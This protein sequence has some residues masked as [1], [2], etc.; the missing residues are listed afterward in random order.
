[1]L[2]T[3]CQLQLKI[4]KMRIQ[5]LVKY[6]NYL[7]RENAIT[8]AGSEIMDWAN[9]AAQEIQKLTDIIAD[10]A[11]VLEEI[12]R[13]LAELLGAVGSETAEHIE[14]FKWFEDHTLEETVSVS[15]Q[16]GLVTIAGNGSITINHGASMEADLILYLNLN[17]GCDSRK[18]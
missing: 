4:F 7:E 13:A 5:H 6:K 3:G 9:T 12:A 14:S 15:K 2:R 8:I 17:W 11:K 18:R 16:I 10:A 1:M